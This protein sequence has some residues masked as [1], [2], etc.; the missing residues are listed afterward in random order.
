MPSSDEGARLSA[1]DPLLPRLRALV[2][3]RLGVEPVALEPLHQGM[4]LRR[5]YRVRLPAGVRPASAVARLEA[6]E[7]PERR[8]AG[9]P[10]EPALEPLRSFL[11]AAGLPVPA[12]LARDAEAGIELLEDLGQ[13]SLADAVAEASGAERVALY[14]EACELVPRLQALSDPGGGLPAFQRRLG[15]PF[16][17]YKAEFFVRWS[18]PQALGRT[19]RPAEAEV[20]QQAFAAVAE[21]TEAAPARLSHRDFQSA[22]LLLRPA[23]PVGA[24]LV[25]IDLQGAWLAPPEYDLVC[26]L[27]DSYVEL[28]PEEQRAQLARVRP[29]LPDAPSPEVFLRRFDLLT[30]TR[31]GK[32]HAVFLYHASRGDRRWLRFVPTTV[33]HLRAAATALATTDLRLGRLAELMV[34]LPEQPCAR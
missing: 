22:N 9:L 11:E 5:F 19:A 15:R 10:P 20:V 28:A 3:Q 14:T 12:L 17:D 31:K 21:A 29:L 6:P 16:F 23:A 18:L 33:R 13:R 24:R 8:P 1:E 34:A 25:M 4:A 7:D 26:L 27:R 30:L 2:R 32:D